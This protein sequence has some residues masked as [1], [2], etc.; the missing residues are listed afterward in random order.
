MAALTILHVLRAPVGGLFRHVLDLAQG[1]AARGH[2]VGIVVAQTE[3]GA[4]ADAKL[5]A[6]A[7]C[8]A[9]GVSRIPMQRQVGLGDVAAVR[10]V[11]RIV[12]ATAPNVVHGHGAKGGAFSRLASAGALRVYTPHGGSLHYGRWTPQGL[13]YGAAERVLMARTGLFLFES[14][15]AR[16][17]YEAT[18]G[19]P[20]GIVRVVHNGVSADEFEPIKPGPD[21]SDL[22]TIG[23]LRHIKGIDVLI[24]AIAKLRA[25]GRRLTATVVGE[26]PDAQ[27]LQHLTAR[28][29]LS[30]SVRFAGYQPARKAF[31]LGRL[32]IVASRAESLPYI[33]LEAAAAG[34]PMIATRVG[35][36]AEVFETP[37]LLVPPG[38]ASA[39]A[40]AVGAVLDDLPAAQAAA[41]RLRERVRGRF[42]QNSMVDGVLAAYE[43]AIRAKFHRSH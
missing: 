43:E 21:A 35:G 28:H 4:A 33:V 32:L 15:F 31:S 9:L 42:S 25:K 12:A 10:H 27:P 23:E 34:V 37:D 40:Q 14:E 20:H 18:I 7:G 17:T 22:V 8:L 29:G 13:V 16:K 41:L 1:Q 24:E 38:D 3:T 19:V 36:I 11:A 39:L 26:G 30:D 2:R 6:I 5:D